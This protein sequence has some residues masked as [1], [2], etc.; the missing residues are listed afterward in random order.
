LVSPIAPGRFTPVE[1]LVLSSGQSLLAA[2]LGQGLPETELDKEVTDVL[3]SC[4]ETR[5]KIFIRM[6]AAADR[7]SSTQ[8]FKLNLLKTSCF[9]KVFDPDNVIEKMTEREIY[10]QQI[11]TVSF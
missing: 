6:L 4:K 1:L 8:N 7:L 2:D 11:F 3:K 5:K 9:I 10:C